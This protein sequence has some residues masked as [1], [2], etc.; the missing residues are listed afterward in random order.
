V[1]S[2]TLLLTTIS[3]VLNDSIVLVVSL[4]NRRSSCAELTFNVVILPLIAQVP[5]IVPVTPWP[6]VLLM[7][8]RGFFVTRA[9]ELDD[10]SEK[11][12]N[13]SGFRKEID[14]ALE[15]I[16]AVEKHLRNDKRIEG[17]TVL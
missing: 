2:P 11:F 4:F 15:R 13:V 17:I 9:K 10:L 12:A 8:P 16:A 3:S 1:V 6:R 7:K 5:R 14:H